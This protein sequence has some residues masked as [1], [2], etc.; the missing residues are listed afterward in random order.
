LADEMLVE[1]PGLPRRP[2]EGLVVEAGRD[3]GRGQLVE[4]ADVP[5][6]RRPGMLAGGLEP[7]EQF[8]DRGTGVGLAPGAG[9]ELDQGIRLFRSRREEAARP[10]ILEGAAE[11]ALAVGEQRRRQRVAGMALEAPAVET[12]GQGPAAVDLAAGGKTE[13]LAHWS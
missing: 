5:L 3:E 11:Q 10:V 8:R 2:H 4:R 13:G 9:P 6:Q 1:H 7:V 12:E